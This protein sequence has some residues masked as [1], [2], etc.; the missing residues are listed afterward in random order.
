MNPGSGSE[1]GSSQT[2]LE[3]SVV[4]TDSVG[5]GAVN[6]S[7]VGDTSVQAAPVSENTY[8]IRPN[9]HLK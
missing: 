3:S 6:R 7:A 8:T 9:F 5:T 1:F 2:S 4:G